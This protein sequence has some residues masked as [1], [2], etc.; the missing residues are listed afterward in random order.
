[1]ELSWDTEKHDWRV[2]MGESEAAYYEGHSDDLYDDVLLAV[3]ERIIDLYVPAPA[4]AEA[5]AR[6]NA[7]ADV[8]DKDGHEIAHFAF[9]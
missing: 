2:A 4:R 8:F 7:G 3:A 9:Y 1:M 6:L 5:H